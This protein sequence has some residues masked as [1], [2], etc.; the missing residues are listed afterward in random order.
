MRVVGGQVYSQPP[1]FSSP[2]PFFSSSIGGGGGGKGGGGCGHGHGHSLQITRESHNTSEF[3][4]ND[5]GFF[6]N[7]ARDVIYKF[8]VGFPGF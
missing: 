1:L 6:R 7:H 8:A 2:H 3:E 5:S 4:K